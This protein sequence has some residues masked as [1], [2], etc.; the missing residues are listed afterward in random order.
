[1]QPRRSR[2]SLT[3]S[4]P[5]ETDSVSSRGVTPVYSR[6]NYLI[7]DESSRGLRAE[8]V[9]RF[10]HL[11]GLSDLF[12]HFVDLRAQRDVEFQKILDDAERANRK[13]R[14]ST[15]GGRRDRP[16]HRQSVSKDSE[17]SLIDDDS[18]DEVTVFTESP[19]FINGQLR[20]YQIDGLNWMISLY[21]NS[22]SGILADEMGLGKTLQTISFLT[23]LR[24]IRKIVG[25]HL[26]IV[27]KSTVDNWAREF[28][29]WAPQF[30]VLVLSGDKQTR[31]ELVRDRLK[32]CD[33]DVC[34]TSFELVIREKAALKRFAWQYIVVDEAHRIKNEE[35][36]LS[37]IVRL[38]FS[39]HRLL[40]TGTP[41][42]NNLHELWAL[43]N[44]LLPDVFADS[45]VFDE[46]FQSENEDQ[47]RVVEQLHRLLRPFL[48]RRVKS[49]VER[50][51]LPKKEINI[52]VGMTDMQIQWYQKLLEKDLD[53]INGTD[54]RSGESKMRLLNVVMQLRK[55]CNHPY[56]FEG[57]EPG[58]P[59]TTDEHIITNSAKMVVLD[60][61][62]ARL[63]EQGSR[64]LIFSQ[65]SRMLDILEDY[66]SFRDYEYCRIDGSTEHEDRVEAID[67]FNKPGSEKM[68]FLLTT[69]AGGLGINLTTADQVVLYDSDW[70]PQ[71]DL[72]AMDRAHRIGQT[73]QVVVYRFVT[74]NAIEEKVLERAAQ[75]L[76]LDQ[77]VI[78]QGRGSSQQDK[79]K[80]AASKEEL[81]N[82]IRHG[83]QTVFDQTKGTFV[84]ES[85]DDIIRN[86]ESRTN[87]LNMKYSALGLDELQ[88]FTFD[89][90]TQQ[91]VSRRQ[92][93]VDSAEG[94]V[95]HRR[96]RKELVYSSDGLEKV[97][98]S[99]PPRQVP[100]VDYQFFP[101]ELE[102]LQEK[103][104]TY[105]RKQVG[106]R[107]TTDDFSDEDE[108]AC[109]QMNREIEAA[110]PLTE[111]E[112][113]RKE[114]LVNEGFPMFTKRD[115]HHFMHLAAK[116]GRDGI[117]QIVKEWRDKDESTVRRYHKVFF[118]RFKE[119]NDY[120]R[121]M[122]QIEAGESRSRKQ[123]YQFEILKTKV[124]GCRA[125]LSEMQ[126]SYPVSNVR[127]SY[128][129]DEDRFLLVAMYELGLD[130]PNLFEEIR[131]RI[132]TCGLFDYDWYF[133]SRSAVEIS[134]R[135]STLLLII[136]REVDGPNALKRKSRKEVQ[137]SDE[138]VDETPKRKGR[139]KRQ[140]ERPAT[141]EAS[142]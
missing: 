104:M 53:A 55:C 4:E 67:E 137:D 31:A 12:R 108:E 25:P 42:Q 9:N 28:S 75:K 68:I 117:D 141:E 40:I 24:E 61:L 120:E 124:T 7:D 102:Q 119:L 127:R 65:M 39:R 8:A 59:F 38:L 63:K 22:L 13:H 128:S 54:S 98:L 129:E 15:G 49:D 88:K 47:E 138:D 20:N 100:L 89:H 16:F 30:N 91:I 66:C 125:P 107:V 29:K 142:D 64:V 35:S 48:L 71:A 114:E 50:S 52:Y 130:T 101:P 84:N 73:K 1:M 2:R 3:A 23:Y 122:A 118:D 131:A 41:L 5:S 86:G 111:E 18:D 140:P 136:T 83:A 96:E 94:D 46:W 126:I 82:M 105:Y 134:R 14:A 58:P 37:K 90:P 57:A 51:L 113:V 99:R 112:Q 109:E 77:L 36:I 60:K 93:S 121:Y 116:Y 95:R 81:V 106:V 87:E 69:R 115:F 133:M 97:R 6:D 135:C 74:E 45:E 44:F 27:P 85:I 123:N 10:K 139:R 103:E 72:Q 132:R 32:T 19:A 110:E 80:Q 70:N 78:Q 43:L 34:I 33:F 11:L 62:L 56:L 26:V 17:D 79:A 92:A 76:R 21:T